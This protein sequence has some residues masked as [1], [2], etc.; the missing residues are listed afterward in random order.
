MT[1]RQLLEKLKECDDDILDFDMYV[2]TT[3]QLGLTVRLSAK[4]QVIKLQ[5][6]ADI[7]GKKLFLKSI[8]TPA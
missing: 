6:N 5:E 3:I 1:G 2:I 7:D 8:T 4:C